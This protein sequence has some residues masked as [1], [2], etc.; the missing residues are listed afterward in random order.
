[1]NVYYYKKQ[2]LD[3]LIFWKEIAKMSVMPVLISSFAL[4]VTSNIIQTDTWFHLGSGIVIFGFIYIL[5]FV[6]FSMNQSERQ[7]ILNPLRSIVRK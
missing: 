4:Y 5:L 2:H 7:L 3:V 6:R 1:M